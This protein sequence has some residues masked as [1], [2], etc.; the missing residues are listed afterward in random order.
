M[1]ETINKKD[2][3]EKNGFLKW[4]TE[5]DSPEIGIATKEPLNEYFRGVRT[6]FQKIEWPNREQ[7]ANELMAVLVIVAA[8]TAIVYVIDI[9]LDK[10]IAVIKG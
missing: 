8:I 9:G 1:Q 5:D 2:K 3:S 4:L 10:A 6:E 7:I